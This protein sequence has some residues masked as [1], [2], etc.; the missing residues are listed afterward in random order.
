MRPSIIPELPVGRTNGSITPCL[1]PDSAAANVQPASQRCA[2][3]C[4]GLTA[5]HRF[6]RIQAL[7][8]AYCEWGSTAI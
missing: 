4:V 6:L 3:R 7:R 8:M 1:R 5:N 2:G